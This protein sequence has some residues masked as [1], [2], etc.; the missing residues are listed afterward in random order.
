MNGVQAPLAQVAPSGP[1]RLIVMRFHRVYMQY[2][3]QIGFTVKEMFQKVGFTYV[4]ILLKIK[5]KQR[6]LVAD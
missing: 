2:F 6:H 4:A 1:S 3:M 5:S